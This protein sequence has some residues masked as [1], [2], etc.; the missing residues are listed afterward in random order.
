MAFDIVTLI[1]LSNTPEFETK[2]WVFLS[3]RCASTLNIILVNVTLMAV[4]VSLS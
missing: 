4:F 2:F 1:Y 3:V